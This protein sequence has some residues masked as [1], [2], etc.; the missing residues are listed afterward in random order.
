VTTNF[1]G[2][3]KPLANQDVM[4]FYATNLADLQNDPA[5]GD[6]FPDGLIV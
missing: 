5:I 4:N 2:V 3:N 1:L 6:L